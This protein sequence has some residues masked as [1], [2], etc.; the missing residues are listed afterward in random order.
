[1]SE[2]IFFSIKE[3]ADYYKVD[4]NTIYRWLK[5]KLI[6]YEKFRVKKNNIYRIRYSDIQYLTLEHIWEMEKAVLLMKRK[7][8]L[9]L[10]DIAKQLKISQT[11]MTALV[12]QNTF[13]FIKKVGNTKQTYIID[14]QKYYVWLK[15]TGG[16]FE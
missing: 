15:N 16:K 3:V 13:P 4:I 12:K 5:L 2:Q 1:M 8:R 6:P 10:S 11:T 9:T 14:E 7:K